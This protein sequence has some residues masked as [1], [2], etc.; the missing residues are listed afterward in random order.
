MLSLGP[1]EILYEP[2][3]HLIGYPVPKSHA[4]KVQDSTATFK[5]P[6]HYIR[7]RAC[8][9]LPARQKY[10]ISIRI[11]KKLVCFMAATST[12]HRFTA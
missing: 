1:Q 3:Y 10:K 11:S 9:I 12:N 6:V 7:P 8:A 2:G 5:T 4:T